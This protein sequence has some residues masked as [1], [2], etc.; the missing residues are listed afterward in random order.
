MS[1]DVL[2]GLVKVSVIH[3]EGS[4]ASLPAEAFVIAFV[5]S[6]DP[7]TA[8]GLDA[9]HEIGKGD[10]FGQ[11]GE[12]MDMVADAPDFHRDAAH[13]AD[14][15]ADVGEYLHKVLIAY[16]HAMVLDVEYDVDVVFCE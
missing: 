1:A 10:G 11:G 13:V 3:R 5:Q 8:I 12:D 14:E 2:R 16:L 9:F 4:V 7:L 15:A 6:L